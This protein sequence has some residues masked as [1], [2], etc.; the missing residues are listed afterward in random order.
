MADIFNRT[1]NYKSSF[2]ADSTRLTFNIPGASDDVG[3]LVQSFNARYVQQVSRLY[4][5][6]EEGAVYFVAGRTAGDATLNKV[7]GPASLTKSFYQ[8]FGDVC[9]M[10]NN[11]ITLTGAIG[12]STGNTNIELAGITLEQCCIAQFG[13]AVQV[14][15]ALI[16]ENTGMMF[17]QLSFI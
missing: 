1:Q 3:L 8:T 6:S 16:F 17:N 10:G 9:T 7:I 4:D 12:C 5:L 14:Q 13:I 11:N 2:S 15:N